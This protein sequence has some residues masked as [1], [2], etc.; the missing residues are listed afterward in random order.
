LRADKAQ[1]SKHVG[2]IAWTL[3]ADPE[4]GDYGPPAT[5]F[6]GAVPDMMMTACPA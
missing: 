1:A 3:D 4:L 6:S 2:V 5:L